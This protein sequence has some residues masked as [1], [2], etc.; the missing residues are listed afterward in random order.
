MNTDKIKCKTGK[1]R[2]RYCSAGILAGNHGLLGVALRAV[3]FWAGVPRRGSYFFLLAQEKSNQKEG[4]PGS[5][6]ARWSTPLRCSPRRAPSSNQSRT[7]AIRCA[8]TRSENRPPTAPGA[9]ALL[10]GSQGPRNAS[11]RWQPVF[12]RLGFS[13]V[14][15][16]PV[17]NR[18]IRSAGILA[19]N[20]RHF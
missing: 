19:G 7:R 4:H 11:R 10:G 5:P 14:R 20:L 2:A 3:C 17:S 16:T 9:A 6:V 8:A 1:S 15:S 12:V 13:F 18:A